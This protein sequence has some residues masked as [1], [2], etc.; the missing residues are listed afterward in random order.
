MNSVLRRRLNT[1]LLCLALGLPACATRPSPTRSTDEQ[2]WSGR[3][4]L[5][6]ASEPAQSLSGGFELRAQAQSGEL[7]LLSPL[8]NQMAQLDWAPGLAKLD[9]G[10][11]IYQQSSLDEL[12]IQLTGSALPLLAMIDWLQAKPVQVPGWVADLSQMR[13]GRLH[14]QSEGQQPSVQLRLVLEP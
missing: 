3:L 11:K 13:N 14:I 5:N 12:L 1:G 6:I 8:G 10:G 7:K 2:L 9:L 4:A